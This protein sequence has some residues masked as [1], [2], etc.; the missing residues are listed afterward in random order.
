MGHTNMNSFIC[1][2]THLFIQHMFTEYLLCTMHH[3]WYTSIM[4]VLTPQEFICEGGVGIAQ[5]KTGVEGSTVF[6]RDW[7]K[8]PMSE[9]YERLNVVLD[10]SGE[11]VGGCS[12]RAFRL[13]KKFIPSPWG[14]WMKRQPPD[15]WKLAWNSQQS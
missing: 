1:S 14:W 3:A 4:L 11:L 9:W 13:F 6:T 7:E 8:F 5:G 12:Q 2:F 15:I 10:L